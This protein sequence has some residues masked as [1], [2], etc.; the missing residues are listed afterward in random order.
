MQKTNF[1]YLFKLLFLVILAISCQDQSSSTNQ[2][3]VNQ[4]KVQIEENTKKLLTT[5]LDNENMDQLDML[6]DDSIKF[7]W[8]DK[9]VLDKEG[10]MKACTELVKKHDNKTEIIDLIVEG[11]RAFVLFIW[12]GTVK[13]DDNPKI[14]GKEFS[15]HDCYRLTW[16][17]GKIVEWYTIW[18]SMDYLF[19]LG[20][21]F[22]PPSED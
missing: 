14:K 12:S 19:Q 18:G 22:Q 11:D 3:S 2:Q 1:N 13:E 4:E 15:I 16:E 10:L 21:S 5:F 17:N 9:T 8:P 7:H 20:Y 6:L